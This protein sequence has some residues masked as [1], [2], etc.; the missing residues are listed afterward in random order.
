MATKRTKGGPTGTPNTSAVALRYVL[1][2]VE[3]LALPNV[4]GMSPRAAF[5]AFMDHAKRILHPSVL[6]DLVRP[7]MRDLKAKEPELSIIDIR[8]R[9]REL[10][11]EDEQFL[12]CKLHDL[13]NEVERYVGNNAAHALIAERLGWMIGQV[14]AWEPE[15]FHGDNAMDMPQDLRSAV[16]MER[17]RYSE[18]WKGFS[19]VEREAEV[20]LSR[21]LLGYMVNATEL[22]VEFGQRLEEIAAALNSGRVAT[23]PERSTQRLEWEGSTIEFLTILKMLVKRK[24]VELPST[25][26]KQGEGNVTE[27][28]RRFQ[29]TFIVRKEDESEFTTEGL[30]DRWRGRPMGVDRE[31]QFDIPDAMPSNETMEESRSRQFDIPDATRKR[32]R[33]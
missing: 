5:N 26:G 32:P 1:P 20:M 18:R 15:R 6:H 11:T 7:K 23:A 27:F 31:K 25:G 17:V 24:Y 33:T 29:Q 3:D 9:M 16:A 13:G 4:E 2:S 12:R 21:H 30:A 14:E 10:C 8:D 28:L 22:R 19:E